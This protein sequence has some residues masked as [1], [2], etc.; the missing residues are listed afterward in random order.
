LH[1]YGTGLAAVVLDKVFTTESIGNWRIAALA[2]LGYFAVRFLLPVDFLFLFMSNLMGR[3]FDEN[4][5]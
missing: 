3:S 2:F 1:V 5:K 4:R